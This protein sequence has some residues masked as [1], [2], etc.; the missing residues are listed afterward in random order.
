V[1]VLYNS[2]NGGSLISS[3]ALLGASEHFEM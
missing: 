3:N 1:C 2:A